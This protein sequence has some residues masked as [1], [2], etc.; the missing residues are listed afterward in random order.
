L[1]RVKQLAPYEAIAR[2]SFPFAAYAAACE[3]ALQIEEGKEVEGDL[4]REEAYYV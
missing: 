3:D 4:W 2:E 1:L